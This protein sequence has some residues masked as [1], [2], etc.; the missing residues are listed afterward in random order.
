MKVLNDFPFP[1]FWKKL[2]KGLSDVLE[3]PREVEECIWCLY[4]IPLKERIFRELTSTDAL[5]RENLIDPMGV[6][7]LIFICMKVF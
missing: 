5:K 1:T 7:Y 6:F 2:W 3:L 4:D